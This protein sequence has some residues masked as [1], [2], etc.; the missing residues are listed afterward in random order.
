MHFDT[1]EIGCADFDIV[2]G[3]AGNCLL[4]EPIPK[5]AEYLRNQNKPNWIVVEAAIIP[6][7]YD[8]P[9]IIWDYCSVNRGASTLLGPGMRWN[10]GADFAVPV[11]IKT[12][13]VSSEK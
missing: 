9:D 12:L 5:H 1:V 3:D 2:S 7:N 4:V 8:G 10:Y 6:R 13:T 11:P